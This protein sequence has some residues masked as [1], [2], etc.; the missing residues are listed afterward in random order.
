MAG[1]AMTFP[2]LSE[3]LPQLATVDEMAEYLGLSHQAVARLCRQEKMPG[4][5]KFC[6]RW[7][8]NVEQFRSSLAA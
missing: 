6:G 3:A 7:L 1:I 4:A 2:R 8:I 5:F